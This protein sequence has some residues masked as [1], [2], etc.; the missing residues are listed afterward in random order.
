MDIV[1]EGATVENT[2]PSDRASEK[3]EIVVESA[4]QPEKALRWL[5]FLVAGV[6]SQG[7]G[8][9]P[10]GQRISWK[11]RATGETVETFKRGFGDDTD[12]VGDLKGQLNKLSIAEFEDKWVKKS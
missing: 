10:G 5:G 4:P 9:N 2:G 3:Y 11:N 1:T 6:I 8:F 12:M 7:D